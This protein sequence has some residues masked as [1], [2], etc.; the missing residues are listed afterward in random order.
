MTPTD[1]DVIARLRASLKATADRTPISAGRLATL[2]ALAQE[3]PS[4]TLVTAFS[5]A[6]AVAA[7][8]VVGAVVANAH[9]AGHRSVQSG[10]G[11]PGVGVA[12]SASPAETPTPVPTPVPSAA[13][14][15][16]GPQQSLGGCVP[17]NYYVTASPAE[18][19]GLTYMLPATPT[20]YVL[21]GAWGTISRNLCADSV[22]WY[23]E[24]DPVAGTPGSGTDA[25]QLTVTKV[26]GDSMAGDFASA[27][28]VAATPITVNGTAGYVFD[29]GSGYVTIG[30]TTNG[31][32]ITLAGPGDLASLGHVADSV[33]LLNP[34]DPRIVAPANCQ[35]PPGS[36][37]G[38]DEPTPTETPTPAPTERPSSELTAA[39]FIGP[40]PT[41][42][43]TAH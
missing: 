15:S 42:T 40:L 23:V 14:G 11:G 41:P 12:S 35:V 43:P 30:W 29:K 4:R 18:V 10:A 25:Y 38:S 13:A 5:A 39:P 8:V 3:P 24:Y 17:E 20:G 21:Y 34:T 37:C 36:V 22:T 32:S 33:V 19:A 28:P 9:P 26:G 31:A 16:G 6:A 7:V 1:D 27:R 2:A